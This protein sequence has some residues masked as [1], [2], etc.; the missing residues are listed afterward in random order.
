[1]FDVTDEGVD[2]GLATM[3]LHCYHAVNLVFWELRA[4]SRTSYPRIIIQAA[5]N[6]YQELLRVLLLI[7]FPPQLVMLHKLIK[8]VQHECTELFWCSSPIMI[9]TQELT[10]PDQRD[11]NILWFLFQEF[12]QDDDQTL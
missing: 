8:V 2:G 10:K 3:L 11:P 6:L 4:V 12:S 1:L 9:L 7:E 5:Q